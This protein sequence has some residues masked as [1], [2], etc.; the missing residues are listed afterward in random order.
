M[1]ILFYPYILNN[2]FQSI[3]FGNWALSFPKKSDQTPKECWKTSVLTLSFFLRPGLHLQTSTYV[4]YAFHSLL[5]P[6]GFPPSLLFFFKPLVKWFSAN[7]AVHLYE[8][9]VARAK[10]ES[11]SAMS[12]IFH[13]YF[14]PS[15][16]ENR[17]WVGRE[18]FLVK[19]EWFNKQ[20]NKRS[21]N[22]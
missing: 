5:S 8:F 10:S 21:L 17:K 22:N 6:R 13:K 15:F 16:W 12:Q 2:F 4:Q 9:P 11:I 19:N 1:Y 3:Y 18:F 7:K 14:K 20:D